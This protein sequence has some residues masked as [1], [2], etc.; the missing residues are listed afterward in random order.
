MS[1]LSAARPKAHPTK[2][3]AKWPA[4]P[5]SDRRHARRRTRSRKRRRRAGGKERRS[6]KQEARPLQGRP[7]PAGP[8]LRMARH[9]SEHHQGGILMAQLLEVWLA[10]EIH[11]R[12]RAAHDGDGALAGREEV[13]PDHRLADEA[14]VVFPLFALGHTVH[15]VPDLE[16]AWIFL[17]EAIQR[18]AHQ[19]VGWSRVSV[20]EPQLRLVAGCA[21]GGLRHLPARREAS[22]ASDQ[23][24][25]VALARLVLPCERAESLV[26]ELS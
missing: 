23:V 19:D 6:L 4:R 20:Q 11:H 25:E 15:R 24:Y 2:T 13:I 16:A 22:S 1:K 5:A 10:R 14:G 26:Y 8:S 7:M 12:R 21:Q 17:R 9:R 3:L 18:I